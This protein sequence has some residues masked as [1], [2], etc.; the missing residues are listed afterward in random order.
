MQ[1]KVEVSFGNAI[2]EVVQMESYQ[3]GNDVE[4]YY[5]LDPNTMESVQKT[6]ITPIMKTRSTGK[7]AKRLASGIE[8]NPDNG[9]FY[10]TKTRDEALATIEKQLI[11]LSK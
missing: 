2:I 6:K 8:H 11:I 9:K 1:E 4:V 3:D 5:E 7:M 10:R